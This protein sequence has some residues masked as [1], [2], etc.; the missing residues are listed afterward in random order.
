MSNK[1]KTLNAKT[2]TKKADATKSPKSE[3]K[4]TDNVKSEQP[5]TD[6]KALT[7]F[8]AT[9]GLIFNFLSDPENLQEIVDRMAGKNPKKRKAPAEDSKTK[10]PL[11]PPRVPNEYMMFMQNLPFEHKKK[12]KSTS[13][14]VQYNNAKAAHE[15]LNG[16]AEDSKKFTDYHRALKDSDEEKLEELAVPFR[17]NAAER[18][19]LAS[20]H[21]PVKDMFEKEI[22]GKNPSAETLAKYK[23]MLAN[24]VAERNGSGDE[25]GA[26]DEDADS[27]ESAEAA[28][29]PTKR[30]RTKA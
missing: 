17:K 6:I 16:L 18:Q 29:R 5:S 9:Q 8:Y 3:T 10:D 22:Y 21:D 1:S 2:E 11:Y 12:D 26:D 4:D 13:A 30:Q 25:E 15:L 19:R 24:W 20:I 14:T 27:A 28:K 7:G 23:Q